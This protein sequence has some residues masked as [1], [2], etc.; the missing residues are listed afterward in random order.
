MSR[1]AFAPRLA[2]LA[3]RIQ[4]IEATARPTGGAT[5]AL[6]IPLRDGLPAGSLVEV[7]AT[8]DGGG[9]W[10]LALVLAQAAAQG[11]FLVV[12][13]HEHSFYPPAAAALGVDLQ[14][15]LILRAHSGPSRGSARQ[16]NA[17][18]QA[19]RCP[20]VGA[21]IGRFERLSTAE[22]RSLQLAAET[23]GGAGFLVRPASVSAPSFAAL[24]LF[25]TP[26]P[27][28]RAAR[29]FDIEVL[30]ERGGKAGRRFVLEIDHETG[31]VRLPAGLAAATV[32][33]GAARA[34]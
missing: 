26:R 14:R 2:E 3:R 19:L 17:L 29:L 6:P 15:T 33:A 31:H 4:E 9:A 5:I 13:D 22:Y 7:L 20:A 11:K 12:A 1:A 16:I 27:S 23:E 28:P 24:R 8:A 25:I 21:V 18:V 34:S 30:R 32:D 10:T